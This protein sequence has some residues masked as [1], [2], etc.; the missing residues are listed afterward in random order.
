MGQSTKMGQAGAGDTSRVRRLIEMLNASPDAF[1]CTQHL[2][3]RLKDEGFQQLHETR[4]WSVKSGGSYFTVRNGSA[5]IAFRI[6]TG[7]AAETGMRIIGAHTDSPALKLKLEAARYQ[8]GYLVCPTEVYGGPILSTWL[9]RDLGVSGRI[10]VRDPDSGMPRSQFIRTSLPVA[11][12]PNLAIHLNREVNKGFEYN[13]QD[14]LLAVFECRSSAG[15]SAADTSR[16]DTPEGDLEHAQMAVMSAVLESAVLQFPGP[17][18]GGARAEEVKAEDVIAADLVLYDGQPAAVIGSGD[19]ALL[20]SGRIDNQAGCFTNLEALLGS[21]SDNNTCIAAFFDNEEI[22]SRSSHGADSSFLEG[23]ID[24]IASCLGLGAE[25]RFQMRAR[26]SIL[27][28]DGAH[29]VHP[30]YVSKMDPA[31]APR[32]NGGPVV[33]LNANMRYS[34]TSETAAR[35]ISLC[36]SR[37]LP[38]QRLANRSDMPSGSTIGPISTAR[39]GLAG[40]D[41]GIPM[42]AMH[43]VRESCGCADVERLTSVI[44]DY[45]DSPFH[46]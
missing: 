11:I 43:S 18:S 31:Y 42:L 9:D 35:F 29:A 40:V 7:N 36:D 10:M 32:L 27:S 44:S 21:R 22:G 14:H 38:Y 45:L 46:A 37:S 8:N 6:G 23:V 3:G 19:D 25:E 1:H 17:Q 39:A 34:S 20:S 24:R 33:K 15:T 4:P 2:I 41:V 26:S 30:A 5:V 16:A 12:V 13:K 28:N